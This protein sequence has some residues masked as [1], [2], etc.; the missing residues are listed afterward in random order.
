MLAG[1]IIKAL[2]TLA[3]VSLI[4]L[5]AARGQVPAD[6]PASRPLQQA[7]TAEY[8]S[9]AYLAQRLLVS[10][11]VTGGVVST[12]DA[13][14]IPK[15]D[16]PQGTALGEAL[17]RV[18][19]WQDKYFWREADGVVNVLGRQGLPALLETTISSF[20]WQSDC[21]PTAWSSD[22]KGCPKCVAGSRA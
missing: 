12:E 4:V 11:R 13:G 21:F 10:A 15:I 19:A 17:T 8:E 3:A 1:R 20:T 5:G 22:C 18:L 6:D 7:V 9:P 14:K 16:L 2:G